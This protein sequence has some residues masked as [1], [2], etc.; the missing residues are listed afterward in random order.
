M[1]KLRKKK[2]SGNRTSFYLDIYDNGKRNYQ[3][4]K[5]YS[6][7]NDKIQNKEITRLAESIRAKKEIELRSA[8]YGFTPEHKSKVNFLD[9]MKKIS[10]TKNFAGKK[11]LK[12]S[13]NQIQKYSKNDI[14]LNA[15]DE[16]WIRGYEEFLISN[17]LSNSTIIDYLIALRVTLNTA[18]RERLIPVNP[19]IYYKQ[20]TKHVQSKRKFLT[21][22]ELITL[23]NT[24]CPDENIKSAFLFSCFTGLRISDITNLQWNDIKD[25]QIEIRQI[26]TKNL[27]YLPLSRTALEIL[28]L[29]R[30]NI[31]NLDNEKIFK[32]PCLSTILKYLREWV[33]SAGITKHI[34]THCGR[35]TFATLSISN[36]IDLYTVSKLMGHSKIEVTQIYAKIVDQK[37][38]EAVNKLP[39]LKIA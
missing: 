33:S 11:L 36:G 23:N 10:E 3:F 2:I 29:H 8:N 19:F 32:L 13:I 25:K 5:L 38:I 16:N 18:V 28:K 22:E 7:N 20:I 6:N 4:L 9:Y 21:F 17:K 15:I 1:V 37:K 34:T 26:K 35:H 27:L 30:G 12:C 31:Y 14:Q 39:Q 24:Y